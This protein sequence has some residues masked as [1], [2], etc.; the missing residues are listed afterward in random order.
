MSQDVSLMSLV[1][2]GVLLHTDNK[3]C[4]LRCPAADLIFLD[5]GCHSNQPSVKHCGISELPK[6]LG[7]VTGFWDNH[8]WEMVI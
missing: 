8:V 6:H 4:L 2:T 5:M 1:M 7:L 3:C